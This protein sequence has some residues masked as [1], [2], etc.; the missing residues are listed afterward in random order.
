MSQDSNQ[1]D[2]RF[3]IANREALIGVGLVLINFGWWYGFA[4]GLGSGPVEEYTYVFGFPAW[5]FY[6]CI[7]G[8]VVMAVLVTSVVKCFFTYVPFELDNSESESEGGQE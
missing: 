7:V 5:F 4:Y 3:K 6:S 2:P 8:F 1:K